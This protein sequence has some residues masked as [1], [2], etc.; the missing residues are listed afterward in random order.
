MAD[1][2]HIY[3]KNV[4]TGEKTYLINVEGEK[5][6]YGWTGA[7]NEVQTQRNVCDQKG[8]KNTT[9]HSEKISD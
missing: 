7:Y 5:V 9:W 8:L 1:K 4:H 2:Y 6:V 3:S